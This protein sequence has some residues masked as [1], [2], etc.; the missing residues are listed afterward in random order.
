MA[1]DPLSAIFNLGKSA[2]D[3][4]WPDP[5]KRAEELRKLEELRQKGDLAEL[6]AYVQNMQGQLKVNA[7]EA[8]HKSIFVAG[9]RPFIGWVGGFSLAYAGILHP[10]LMWLWTLLQ[11]SGVIPKEVNPPPFVETGILGT[12]VTG[13]LGIG[14]MR[15]FDKSKGNSPDSIKHR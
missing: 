9:W 8:G 6:N 14:G 7:I 1:F 2:I 5:I 13:M 3:K 12:I 11:A 4:I 15:S 10:L